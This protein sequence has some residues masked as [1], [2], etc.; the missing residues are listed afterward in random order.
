M[1]EKNFASFPSIFARISKF[2]HFRSD[3]AYAEP[4]FFGE[5][6]NIFFL[7]VHFGPIRWGPGFF[8][9]RNLHLIWDFWVILENI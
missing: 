4:N 6:S 7:K 2:E 5:I 1:L 9:S 8:I 3:W